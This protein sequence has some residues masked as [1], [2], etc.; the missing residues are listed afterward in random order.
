MAGPRSASADGRRARL[1]RDGC[2][3]GGR[4]A[5]GAGAYRGTDSG[6]PAAPQVAD[7]RGCLARVALVVGALAVAQARR[8]DD[9][10]RGPS[11]GPLPPRPG[12]FR[13]RPSAFR[14]STWR[15]CWPPRRC[16]STSP[17][18]HAPASSR[19]WHGR[20][21]S[22]GRPAS[23]VLDHV[24]RRQPRRRDG[25]RR[26]IRRCQGVRRRAVAA[27]RCG[28]RVHAVRARHRAATGGA[29]DRGVGVQRRRTGRG[30]GLPAR[31]AI[32]SRR[33]GPGFA[34]RP[35]RT[36]APPGDVR[37]IAL[38]PDG[39]VFYVMTT[40]PDAIVSIDAESGAQIGGTAIAG[41]ALLLCGVG[42]R[43][44]IV[45]LDEELLTLRTPTLDM[46]RRIDV[47]S[48]VEVVRCSHDG[49]TVA[50]ASADGTIRLWSVASGDRID[51]LD[52]HTGEIH[53]LGSTPTIL[54]STAPTTTR[55]SSPGTCKGSHVR[56]HAAARR[57]RPVNAQ[58]G[59]CSLR[60]ARR[61]R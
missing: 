50:S 17:L 57:S 31:R 37:G 49:R 5:G 28:R 43:R 55:C 9:H 26:W 46:V 53:T 29:T 2:A 3:P 23:T 60:T 40:S 18:T 59:Y 13:H 15:C 44:L 1:P 54:C 48:Q 19:C 14:T 38:S 52:V 8:A 25:P 34:R 11:K 45:A 27:D 36:I 10:R 16:G 12:E 20:V 56:W 41:R 61:R 42:T 32:A 30:R 33:L 7:A 21:G 39:A 24:A 6:E 51:E 47:T 35:M 4:A 58:A 22:T